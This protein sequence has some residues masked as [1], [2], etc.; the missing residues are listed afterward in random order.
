M[1]EPAL[2]AAAAPERPDVPLS[3]LDLS[4]VP[5]GGTPGDALR[6]SIDLAQVAERAGYRR[7]WG[8]GPPPGAGGGASSAPGLGALLAAG[9]QRVPGGAGAAPPPD[10]GPPPGGGP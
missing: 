2:P 9:T 7:Y 10:T 8:A 4:P 6:N 3:I 5:A 1:S